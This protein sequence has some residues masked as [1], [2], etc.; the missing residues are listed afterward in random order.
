MLDLGDEIAIHTTHSNLQF[1][2][3]QLFNL[4]NIQHE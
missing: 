4:V 1:N 2:T 3:Q